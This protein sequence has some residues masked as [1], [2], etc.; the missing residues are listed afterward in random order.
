M[1]RENMS[2]FNNLIAIKANM[3]GGLRIVPKQKD[4]TLSRDRQNTSDFITNYVPYNCWNG[5]FSYI[6]YRSEKMPKNIFHLFIKFYAY[7]T[8]IIFTGKMKHACF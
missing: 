7:K 4:L 5:T 3:I 1:V 8:S 6:V 2:K